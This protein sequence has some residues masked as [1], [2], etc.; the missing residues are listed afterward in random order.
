MTGLA[1]TLTTA[2]L[3]QPDA[4]VSPVQ[5]APTEQRML[6]LTNYDRQMNHFPA[7]VADPQTLDIARQ[8]ASQ[9]QGLAMPVHYDNNGL[10]VFLQMLQQAQIPYY[11]GAGENLARSYPIKPPEDIEQAF[12]NSPDHRANIMDPRW[13]KMAVGQWSD[14]TRSGEYL[15]E[16]YR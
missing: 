8:R 13:T 3:G 2:A 12:L 6:E 7:L 11:A 14:P 1:D 5:M 10:L 4:M 16:L 15:A 9:Q